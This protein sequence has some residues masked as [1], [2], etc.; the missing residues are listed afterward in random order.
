MSDW[1]DFLNIPSPLISPLVR[2]AVGDAGHSFNMGDLSVAFSLAYPAANLAIGYP[3]TI[4]EIKI[5]SKLFIW[6]RGNNTG[7]FDIGIYDEEF[8]L[9]FSAG[10]TAAVSNT[11]QTFAMANKELLPGLY[12]CAMVR[13]NTENVG[14]INN[15]AGGTTK[16]RYTKLLGLWQQAIG[17]LPLPATATPVTVGQTYIPICGAALRPFV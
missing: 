1:P 8:N 11:I 9:L 12:Y 14:A 3:F 7:N 16:F 2:E 6:N 10:T 4:D 13:S 5:V 15:I 17:A